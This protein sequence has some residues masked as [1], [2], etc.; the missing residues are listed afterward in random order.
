MIP[1]M[2]SQLSIIQRSLEVILGGDHD[3]VIKVHQKKQATDLLA[4]SRQWQENAFQRK[5]G[6]VIPCVCVGSFWGGGC[7]L[8]VYKTPLPVLYVPG[9]S[10][11]WGSACSREREGGG[12][13]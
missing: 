1:P 10:T 13:R 11:I 12:N 9:A 2:H 7:A 6:R 5:A 8:Y 3:V 4:L